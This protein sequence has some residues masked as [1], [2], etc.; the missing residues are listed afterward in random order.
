[1][2]KRKL[3]QN[4]LDYFVQIHEEGVSTGQLKQDEKYITEMIIS[5]EDPSEPKGEDRYRM[6]RAMYLMK[7]PTYKPHDFMNGTHSLPPTP[8]ALPKQP[9]SEIGQRDSSITLEESIKKMQLALERLGKNG[10]H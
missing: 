7:Y 2:E 8:K 3:D 4:V 9:L 5:M 6:A 1:M 10:L